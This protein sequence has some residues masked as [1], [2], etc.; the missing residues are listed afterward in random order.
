MALLEPCEKIG[1]AYLDDREVALCQGA[2]A[3]RDLS[4]R[5]CD[6]DASS[7]MVEHVCLS[8]VDSA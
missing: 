7:V 5:F 6:T 4:R 3:F 8:A 2:L 1:K